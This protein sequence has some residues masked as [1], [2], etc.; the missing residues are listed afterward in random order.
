M[1]RIQQSIC[2]ENLNV[3]IGVMKNIGEKQLV[4]EAAVLYGD[5]EVRQLLEEKVNKKIIP[6][7]ILF[8]NN[9]SIRETH[10]VQQLEFFSYLFSVLLIVILNFALIN[11]ELQHA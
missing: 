5:R 11:L 8:R 6:V 10:F 9:L 3:G 1:T 4:N 2:T 7:K